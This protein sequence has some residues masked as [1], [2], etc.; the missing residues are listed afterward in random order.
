MTYTHYAD[1]LPDGRVRACFPWAGPPAALDR[2]EGEAVLLDGPVDWRG[3]TPTSVLHYLDGAFAW[4]EMAGLPAA[5][6]Y[7][8]AEIDR[9]ADAV[10]LSVAGDAARIEEYKVARAEALAYCDAGFEGDPP[11]YVQAWV[12]P[13]KRDAR[14]AAEDILATADR[15]QAILLKIRQLRLDAKEDV[16]DILDAAAAA[17]VLL[18]F[19]ADLMTYLEYLG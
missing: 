11:P 3:P 9:I 13:G 15:F 5:Q 2:A 8:I 1:V 12:R 6:A 10:R 19:T 17:A 14:Q 16:R 18:N 4:V 7:A